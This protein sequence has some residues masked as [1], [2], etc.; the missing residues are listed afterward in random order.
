MIIGIHVDDFVLTG[1]DK[2]AIEKV[3]EQLKARFEMKDL[4][5]AESIL[6]I[7][8]QRQREKLTIN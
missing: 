7:Q 4:R 3:K 5:E 2:V 8:I 6:G 1:E